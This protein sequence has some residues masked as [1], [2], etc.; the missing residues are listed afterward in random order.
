MAVKVGMRLKRELVIGNMGRCQG[1]GLFD[2]PPGLFQGL[3]WQG[4]HH[5]DI[6]ILEVCSPCSEDCLS[7]RVGIVDPSKGM[8]QGIVKALYTN[9]DA[10]DSSASKTGKVLLI[11]SAGIGFNCNFRTLY[12]TCFA[13]DSMQQPFN[14]LRRKQAG[15]TPP[16]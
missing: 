16:I 1:D 12:E 5:V 6:D 10:I 15:R 8:Q 13:S 3:A 14:A 4:I 9:R 7:R 2:I 11:E